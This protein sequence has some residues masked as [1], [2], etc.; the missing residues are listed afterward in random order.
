MGTRGSSENFR[1]N[2][3]RVVSWTGSSKGISIAS[4]SLANVSRSPPV[5]DMVA[6]RQARV[7]WQTDSVQL[8]CSCAG[9]CR[10]VCRPPAKEGAEH[11]P[12]KPIWIWGA[13]EMGVA[14]ADSEA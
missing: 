9:T 6:I 7:E 3:L 4:S 5:R 13:K 11:A 8:L 10:D 1:T 14:L 2:F 12:G